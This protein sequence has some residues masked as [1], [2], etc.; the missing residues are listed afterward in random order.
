VF[1]DSFHLSLFILLV[2]LLLQ[3]YCKKEAYC[4]SVLGLCVAYDEW[5]SVL[6]V[7]DIM[8][9]QGWT[10]ERSSYSACLQASFEAGNGASAH[11]I[12]QAMEKAAVDPTPSDIGLTVAAMCRNNHHHN[13]NRRP[14]NRD[15][16]TQTS[17]TN[18]NQPSSAAAATPAPTG[19]W[20][21][22][23]GLIQ[24]TATNTKVGG[25]NTL[26]PVQAYDAVLECMVEERQWK[27]AVRLLR[28]MEEGSSFQHTK[29]QPIP[30]GGFHPAPEVSTY[31]EVIEC[32]VTTNQAE[33]A[34]QVLYSMK[35]RGV[36]VRR[37]TPNKTTTLERQG[38]SYLMIM[39]VHP[40]KPDPLSLSTSFGLEYNINNI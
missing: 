5:E 31:R 20:R 29:G 16:H 2:L 9:R 19:W 35:N 30:S 15:N 25:G 39:L 10:Q 34:V 28:A 14:T 40:R 27:E 11:D 22:A 6:E 7:L 1:D 33:Q 24:S 17:T 37:R 26:I 32:C 18:T 23:L 36:K 12:L 13:H 21:K 4:D 3:Y 38:H 8:K